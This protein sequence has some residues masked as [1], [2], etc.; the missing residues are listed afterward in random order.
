MLSH[1]YDVFLYNPKEG[2]IC[3]C[4]QCRKVLAEGRFGI[5]VLVK[6]EYSLV[7]LTEPI[8]C[9]Q[10]D[11]LVFT[12]FDQEEMA[13]QGIQEVDDFLAKL[14]TDDQLKELKLYRLPLLGAWKYKQMIT[15]P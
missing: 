3:K 13:Q 8:R 7:C 14:A 5:G 6:D 9:C 4:R 12:L 10:R 2:I 11:L 15:I 1:D